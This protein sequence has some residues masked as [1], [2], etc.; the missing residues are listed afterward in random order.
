M[1]SWSC[2]HEPPITRRGLSRKH[3]HSFRETNFI[4]ICCSYFQLKELKLSLCMPWRHLG[5]AEVWLHSF[6][7]LAQNEGEFINTMPPALYLQRRIPVPIEGEGGQAPEPLWMIQRREKSLAS[8]RIWTLDSP[9]HNLVTI[10]IVLY[11]L[12][13]LNRCKNK[14]STLLLLLHNT[15]YLLVPSFFQIEWMKSK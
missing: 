2:A 15:E 14:W 9:A 1:P 5:G 8:V 3:L 11:W 13:Y 4:W 7:T 6:T 10:L 12:A